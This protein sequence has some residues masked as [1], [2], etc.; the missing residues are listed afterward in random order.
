MKSLSSTKAIL[1]HREPGERKKRTADDGKG[2]EKKRALF[3]SST[4]RSLF[5]LIIAHK[6]LSEYTAGASAEGR[7]MKMRSSG[8]IAMADM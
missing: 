2:K 4:A 8:G 3:A 7:S 5:F 6:F 1:C